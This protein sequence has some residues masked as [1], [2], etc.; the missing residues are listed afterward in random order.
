MCGDEGG[1][2]EHQ[3]SQKAGKSLRTGCQQFKGSLTLRELGGM[4][5]TLHLCSRKELMVL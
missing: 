5:R 1:S 2:G 4:S 3:A